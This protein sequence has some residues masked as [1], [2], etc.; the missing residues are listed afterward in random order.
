[1][2]RHD[3]SQR[4]LTGTWCTPE[5]VKAVEKGYVILK[6]HEVWHFD[7]RLQGL[8]ENYVNTWLKLKEEAS[9][10]SASCVTSEQRQHHVT[11]YERR[12]GIQL[13]RANIEYNPGKQAVAKLM[14]NSMWGKFDQRID[15]TQVKEFT[16]A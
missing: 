13:D 9:G 11:E 3:P 4:Q 12:E 14:L 16:Q 1:M 7:E 15:K 10:F 8:F 2:C 5:L 6:I